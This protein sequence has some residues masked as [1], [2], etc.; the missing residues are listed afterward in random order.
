M[1]TPRSFLTSL[2]TD[3]R[4]VGWV[5]VVEMIR[6]L[7]GGCLIIFRPHEAPSAW[8]FTTVTVV[9]HYHIIIH[10]ISYLILLLWK[11]FIS[12][13]AFSIICG[14][15][16]V[17]RDALYIT[18][19]ASS[20]VRD[21]FDNIRGTR[22]IIRGAFNRIIRGAW[23]I[24]R[25]VRKYNAISEVLDFRKEGRTFGARGFGGTIFLSQLRHWLCLWC[26]LQH[27]EYLVFLDTC[28]LQGKC[29]PAR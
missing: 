25:G 29:F 20:I 2:F 16:I 1:R 13:G 17:I 9:G 21:A 11:S 14:A 18:R 28:M 12:F 3:D 10:I 6:W 4:W 7:H 19:G 24:T 27:F 26:K 8:V 15:F 23:D 22:N 5:V